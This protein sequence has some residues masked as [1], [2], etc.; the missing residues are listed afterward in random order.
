MSG[1]R[2]ALGAEAYRGVAETIRQGGPLARALAIADSRALVRAL[3][4]ASALSSGL[5]GYLRD[6][7]TVQELVQH[8]G[9]RRTDRLEAW[10]GVGVDLGELRR[11]GDRYEL[12]GSRARALGRGDE[13]LAAHYRSMLEYQVGP[14]AELAELLQADPG[15]GRHDLGRYAADIARVSLAAAPFVSTMIRQVVAELSPRR[16]LDA[17]CGTGVYTRVVLGSGAD[18]E[19]DGVDLAAGVIDAAR[20]Q[21]AEAG[22]GHRARL[23]VGDV[24]DWLRS[25]EE[26]FD[27]ALLLN[28]I[29]YFD[30]GARVGLYRELRTAL[31]DGGQ[32]LVV[33]MTTPGSI[34]AAHLHFMLTCQEGTAS[35]PGRD[36]LV[37]DL[38]AA[39]YEPF[40]RRQLVPTE[41]LLAVRARPRF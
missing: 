24:R 40:E 30:R 37:A 1:R 41:P 31:G 19:V 38:G 27:L 10:L 26:R 9:C 7:P 23:H 5:L 3:F 22:F 39:G 8:T 17:G 20:H 11:R 21:L 16:V 33:S 4:L 36:D 35:L 32:L 25:S 18:V 2:W 13:L 28:N 15:R 29:Y 34:A 6:G 12:R 14:Y